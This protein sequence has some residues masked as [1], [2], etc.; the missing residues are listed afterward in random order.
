MCSVP[1]G[2][3]SPSSTLYK[4]SPS[5]SSSLSGHGSLSTSSSGVSLDSRTA[6]GVQA[7]QP[8]F[9][10]ADVKV[11]DYTVSLPLLAIA[12][13]GIFVGGLVLRAIVTF[14][15][16]ILRLFVLF[17]VIG[18]AITISQFSEKQQQ[19]QDRKQAGTAGLPTATGTS[20]DHTA[21]DRPDRAGNLLRSP[22]VLPATPQRSYS[23]G[24]GHIKSSSAMSAQPSTTSSPPAYN[25]DGRTRQL[26]MAH[27][28][29]PTYN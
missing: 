2:L 21:D 15:A 10:V 9:T 18:A 29:Y 23:S 11:G 26:L 25:L 7:G 19:A 6:G 3:D 8:S 20:D 27:Q 12:G 4:K 14:S 28:R 16:S 24:Y 5:T 1:P 22:Y 17:V 13:V